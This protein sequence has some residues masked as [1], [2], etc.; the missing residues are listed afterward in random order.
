MFSISSCYHFWCAWTNFPEVSKIRS[1]YIFAIS[2][3]KQTVKSLFVAAD[4]NE[5]FLEADSITEQQ[6]TQN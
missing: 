1:L 6:S 3:E 2:P 5:T 4:K